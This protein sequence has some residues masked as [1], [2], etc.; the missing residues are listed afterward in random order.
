M[1]RRGGV[2]KERVYIKGEA[3][4]QSRSHRHPATM[5]FNGTWKVDRSENYDKF[6]EQ[7]GERVKL[8]LLSG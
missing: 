5:A 7:M 2:V 4:G 1:G 3:A 8:G 6:M